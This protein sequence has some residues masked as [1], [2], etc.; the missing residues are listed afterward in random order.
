MAAVR[1]AA[2]PKIDLLI[3]GHGGF[4]VTISIKATKALESFQS[5]FL[6]EPIPQDNYDA[7]QRVAQ[8]VSIPLAGGERCY[9][10][11]QYWDLSVQTSL[12][13]Y[14]LSFKGVLLPEGEE[15]YSYLTP[16][17]HYKMQSGSAA[18]LPSVS[19]V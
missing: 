4:N 18:N 13:H 12:V 11:Y 17:Q 2:G 15:K 14:S 19:I 6:E 9:S 10:Y 8:A 3:E 16:F 7:L 1:K 5:Y